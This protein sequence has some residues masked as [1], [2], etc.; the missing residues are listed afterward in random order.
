[1][2]TIKEFSVLATIYSLLIAS[3]L[4]SS[5][6]KK[7]DLLPSPDAVA[8]SSEKQASESLV[9][10]TSSASDFAVR[11]SDIMIKIDH[12]AARSLMPDYCVSVKFDGNIIFEGRRNVS[13]IGKKEWKLDMNKLYAVKKLFE[14]SGF[15]MIEDNLSLLADVPMVSTTWCATPSNIP[16][17]LVDYNGDYPEGLISLRQKAEYILDLT[18]LIYPDSKSTTLN[19]NVSL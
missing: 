3:I 2:K 16:K 7:E 11:K 10:R 6:C 17:T 18:M 12:N 15:N 14:Q 1:M 13:Y 5:G 4:F 9:S 19:G 8:Y